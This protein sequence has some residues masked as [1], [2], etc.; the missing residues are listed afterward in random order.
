MEDIV[1]AAVHDTDELVFS[2]FNEHYSLVA[3]Q[4]MTLHKLYPFINTGELVSNSLIY[5][6]Q[7]L[8]L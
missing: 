6:A 3:F 1:Y 8:N 4:K 7:K 2:L 5:L